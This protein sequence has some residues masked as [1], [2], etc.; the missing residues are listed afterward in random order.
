LSAKKKAMLEKIF[1][2][3]KNYTY[4][5]DFRFLIDGAYVILSIVPRVILSQQA[6][7]LKFSHAN[8]RDSSPAGSLQYGG[9]AE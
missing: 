5:F 4:C 1:L 9:Q 6:K 8:S 3:Y 2:L 7:D